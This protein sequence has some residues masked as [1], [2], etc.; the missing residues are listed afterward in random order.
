MKK[1]KTDRPGKDPGRPDAVRRILV[2]VL[3]QI[4]PYADRGNI[5]ERMGDCGGT[6]PKTGVAPGIWDCRIDGGDSRMYI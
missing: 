5:P 6:A 4:L 3:V 1:K 2:P